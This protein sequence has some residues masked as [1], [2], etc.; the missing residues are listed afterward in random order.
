MLQVKPAPKLIHV[1]CHWTTLQVN[2]GDV[3]HLLEETK[4]AATKVRALST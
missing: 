4:V 1:T 3:D 2:K